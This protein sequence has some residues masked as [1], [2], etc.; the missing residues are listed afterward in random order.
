M[1]SDKYQEKC[2]EYALLNNLQLLP[3]VAQIDREIID[4]ILADPTQYNKYKDVPRQ[5]KQVSGILHD[6][7]PIR[8]M[9]TIGQYVEKQV[10]VA[11]DIGLDDVIDV[12]PEE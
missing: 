7:V 11:Q 2:K 6:S 8:A 10:M 4:L 3:K 12:T 9:I 1:Q 5:V